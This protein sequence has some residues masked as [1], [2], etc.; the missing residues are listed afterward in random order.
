M[1][2]DGEEER[3]GKERGLQSTQSP[4]DALSGPMKKRKENR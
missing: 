4:A 2:K 3:K 1:L